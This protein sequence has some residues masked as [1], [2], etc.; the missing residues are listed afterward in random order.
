MMCLRSQGRDGHPLV[1]MLTADPTPTSS[2]G[3]LELGVLQAIPSW[4]LHGLAV[5]RLGQ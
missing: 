4:L 5:A 3:L 2:F 1:G